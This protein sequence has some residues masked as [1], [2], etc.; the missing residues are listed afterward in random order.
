MK[1]FA[2]TLQSSNVGVAPVLDHG[3]L[4]RMSVSNVGNGDF[5]SS[6]DQ[7]AAGK[8]R[9]RRTGGSRER[10]SHRAGNDGVE[11]RISGVASRVSQSLRRVLSEL[12]GKPCRP[13]QLSQ[14]LGLNRDI[15]GRVLT[16]SRDSDPLAVAHVLPGP[17]PLRKMLRAARRR[18]VS[19]DALVEAELAVQ[20]FEALIREDAGDR[21]ALDAIIS[22]LLPDA[23]AKFELAAKQTCFKGVSLLKGVMADLWLHTAIVH[24]SATSPAHLDVVYVYGTIGLRRL[25]PNMVVK[26]T[27][28]QFGVP[29]QSWQ[30][31]EGRAPLESAGDELD[32]FCALEPARLQVTAA[33]N[34]AVY[35]LAGDGVGPHSATDKLLAEVH[36]R[37]MSRTAS[38]RPRNRKSLFVAPSVPV[39]QLVF[40]LLLHENA[41]PGANP[42]LLLYDTAVDGMAS[43]NDAARDADR[44]DAIESVTMLGRGR[45]NLGVQEMPRYAAMIDHV[46]TKVG[47]DAAK[48]RGYRCRIQYPMHGL[49]ACLAF[50]A[51]AA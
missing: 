4:V 29:D 30:T 45:S 26:F 49:Q 41:Y 10:S 8:E 20:A 16:A 35:A 14:L 21:P 33:G 5:E 48:F 1:N 11:A 13:H 36:R 2:R 40:D 31:L 37:C 15:S 3:Y 43:V 19:D 50:D 51:A 47:W 6:G 12:P 39:K 28:R 27:Y 9:P 32:A 34:G 23:R 24:P 44:L 38:D 7:A 25:R 18:H 42:E 17:E 46:C 22:S